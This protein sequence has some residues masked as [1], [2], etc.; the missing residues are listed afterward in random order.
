VTKKP[1]I[2]IVDDDESIRIA[3]ASLVRSLGY[4]ARSF[5][6]AE[7]FL[8]SD[9]AKRSCCVISDVRMPNMSGLE[10]VRRLRALPCMLPVI[11]VTGRDPDEVH[12]TV[13]LLGNATTLSKPLVGDR[14]SAALD[15][16]LGA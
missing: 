4:S 16:V 1:V 5:A 7:A 15:T 11:F 14:L 3:T 10:M 6:S 9:A 12:H 2:S 8:N 13:L